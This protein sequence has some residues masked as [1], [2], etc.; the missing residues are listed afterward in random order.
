MQKW[1]RFAVDPTK[2]EAA[3]HIT[4][5]RIDVGHETK[6]SSFMPITQDAK[7]QSRLAQEVEVLFVEA[8]DRGRR[9]RRRILVLVILGVVAIVSA[10]AVPPI[11]RAAFWT[12][13]PSGQD[14]VGRNSA[15][16]GVTKI[17]I[18]AK[19]LNFVDESGRNVRTV[20][21]S[22]PWEELVEP[23][24]TVLGTNPRFTDHGKFS[25]KLT[26]PGFSIEHMKGSI[27]DPFTVQV[28][29]TAARIA[30]VSIGTPSGVAVGERLGRVSRIP[31][32]A[33]I[34]SC[35]LMGNPY[36]LDQ[37]RDD[38]AVYILGDNISDLTRVGYV[39]APFA[40]LG[41]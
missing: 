24:K 9:R 41:C 26:W 15:L 36:F 40:Y 31:G 35:S 28:V 27:N 6:D 11:V 7:L 30:K 12:A 23:L 18:G 34:Q 4:I 3:V 21:Y 39:E 38:G 5:G 19:S 16:N 14:P 8:R 20:R 1:T 17:I 2:R 32:L 22:D 10:I 25:E 37:R 29:A 33:T 13:A